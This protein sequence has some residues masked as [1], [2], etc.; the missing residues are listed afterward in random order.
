MTARDAAAHAADA[1]SLTVPDITLDQL[2]D[3]IT[4]LARGYFNT[5]PTEVHRRGK[6]LLLIAQTMLERTQV[7]RQ[8]ERLYLSAGQAAALLSAV[9]FDLGAI[10]A[11]VQLARTSVLYGQVIEHGPLQAYASGALAF[12]AFWDGRPTEAVRLVH[13]AQ[14]HGGLGGTANI[15]LSVIE[16]RAHAHLGNHREAERAIKDAQEQN[17]ASRDDLH[18]DIGGEFAFPAERV[19]MS[20]ATTYLLLRDPT[21]AEESATQALDLLNT[22]PGDNRPLL[23]SAQAGIDMARARLLRRELDGAGEA[24]EPVFQVPIE[25]RGAGMLERINAARTQ[26]T[27]P[28]FR[29]TPHAR[30]LGERIEDFTAVATSRSLGGS[31]RLAIES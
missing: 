11:A 31:G 30:G 18:D 20:N 27:H 15:R 24:L 26:L 1:A 13:A 5:S 6:E 3:D 29:D 9:C 12:L 10:P 8:R 21:G 17:T 4:A 19:A 28:D 7:P 25:W 14:Q 23:I 22:R 16:A 2:H